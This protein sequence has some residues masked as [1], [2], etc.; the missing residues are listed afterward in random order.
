MRWRRAKYNGENQSIDINH[1]WRKLMSIV[2]SMI[3]A[4][5]MAA[6]AGGNQLIS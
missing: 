2:A 5:N 1:Q 6:K 3:M 4:R